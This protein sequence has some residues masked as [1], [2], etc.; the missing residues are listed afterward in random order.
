MGA[1]TLAYSNSFSGVFVFDDRAEILKNPALK[2]LW[3]PSKAMFGGNTLPARPLPYYT[4]ALNYAWDGTNVWGYHAVNLAIHLAAGLVLFG[5]MRRTLGMPRVPARYAAAA[6]GLALAAALLWVVHPLQTES[7]TYIYQRM[8]S[9]MGLF[10]L[11][12]LY[13][14]VRSTNSP[15]PR[16]WL[17]AAVLCS[18]AG[19]ATKE[20]MVTAPLLLLWYDRVFVAQGWRDLFHRRWPFYTALAATWIM[21]FVV[22]CGQAAMYRE[23]DSALM[24]VTPWQYLLNQPIVILHYLR[25]T[26][27]PHGL[28]LHYLW[29]GA[30][31]FAEMVAPGLVLLSLLAAAAWCMVRRPALGFVAGSF[32]LV[33]SVTS[34]IVPVFALIFEHRM[35]LSLAAV[36]MLVVLGG[37]DVLNWLF[38][39][40]PGSPRRRW[41][42]AVPTALIVVALAATTYER[43][44]A[45]ASFLGMWQD[46]AAK[47]PDN[48]IAQRT[49][50]VGFAERHRYEESIVAFHRAIALAHSYAEPD[51]AWL[52]GVHTNLGAS[53]VN[54]GRLAEAMHCYEEAA[55]LDPTYAGVY[56]N[57][58]TLF[59][60]LRQPVRARQCFEK[61]IALKPGYAPS[62]YNLGVVLESTDAEA[63]RRCYEMA[64]SLDADYAPAHNTLGLVSLR[65]GDRTQAIE[66]FERALRSDPDLAS[67]RRNLALACQSP[68]AGRA[69]DRS[70]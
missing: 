41:L 56:V 65:H 9:L 23:L 63:A 7:V 45:Y 52:A 55:R 28:C 15:R 1:G 68:A 33:L 67:A 39:L 66:H 38:P 5:I 53:L 50:G 17:E 12:T 14:F 69:A 3:P 27:F 11:L 47:S 20:V 22:M 25:L 18:A 57:M 26:F 60:K 64:L 54:M 8:E 24:P 34:S 62:Y 13:C 58:G 40:P 2:Q 37:Y 21:L 51:P 30:A 59:G 42:H 46:V 29:P 19:M 6:D 36:T 43:N 4:F 44:F 16:L 49:L 61:A 70:K 32:F 35:Y 31:T 48:E 10:Y